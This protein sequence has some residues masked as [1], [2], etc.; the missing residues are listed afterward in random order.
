M[1]TAKIYLFWQN[2][3]RKQN[4]YGTFVVVF[5]VKFIIYITYIYLYFKEKKN[6]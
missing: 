4:Y 6:I 5:K 3:N 2:G 1:L